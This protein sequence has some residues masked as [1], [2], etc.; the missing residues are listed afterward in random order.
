MRSLWTWLCPWR[1][2]KAL[3]I[4]VI[5]SKSWLLSLCQATFVYQ[6]NLPVLE[7]IIPCQ[8]K[9]VDALRC[10]YRRSRQTRVMTTQPIVFLTPQTPEGS[11]NTYRQKLSGTHQLPQC[12]WLLEELFLKNRSPDSISSVTFVD[13]HHSNRLEETNNI[14]L[15]LKSTSLRITTWIVV[16]VHKGPHNVDRDA[17]DKICSALNIN[18]FFLMSHFYWYRS[19]PDEKNST[20][21]H[22][23]TSPTKLDIPVP[24][25]LPSLVD[26][27]FSAIFPSHLSP[28]TGKPRPQCWVAHGSFY[29]GFTRT[30]GFTR[31]H[32]L[33]S[34][35]TNDAP[36]AC[37]NL[38]HVEPICSA[39]HASGFWKYS[40]SRA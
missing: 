2:N 36:H 38:L 23:D 3:A 10:P 40:F 1:T 11:S 17:L 32:R 8:C 9:N 12:R 31:R 37:Q 22:P 24:I 16:L 15:M 13:N 34:F 25:S 6:G 18:P 33:L 14:Q 28:R 21:D 7:H 19:K 27:Q 26:A 5:L 30:L 29:P 4:W 35:S 39:Y 20:T